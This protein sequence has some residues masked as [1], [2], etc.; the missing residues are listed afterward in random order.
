MRAGGTEAQ[1][2]GGNFVTVD[3]AL[4]AVGAA[5]GDTHYYRFAGFHVR[6]PQAGA[7]GQGFMG[8]SELLHVIDFSISGSATMK[9]LA[10]PACDTH[11]SR[12]ATSSVTQVSDLQAE[13]GRSLV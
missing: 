13:F 3:D 7:E 11:F 10:V 6:N 9:R 8:R 5:V 2:A 4:V 1:V 12:T